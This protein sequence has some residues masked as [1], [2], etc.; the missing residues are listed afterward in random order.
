MDA[1][2]LKDPRQRVVGRRETLKRIIRGTASRVFIARDADPH[3]VA[4]ITQICEDRQVAVEFVDTMIQLGR[5][6]GIDVGAAC[7]AMVPR[8]Q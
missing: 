4:E 8:R 2:A 5:M 3:I 7:A 6:C 1:T